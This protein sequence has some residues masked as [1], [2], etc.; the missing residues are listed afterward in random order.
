MQYEAG[1]RTAMSL[2][3][4]LSSRTIWAIICILF[5]AQA[6]GAVAVQHL[7]RM[8]L[9][10]VYFPVCLLLS[11]CAVS[12][13]FRVFAE[14]GRLGRW[15]WWIPVFLFGFVIF[16]LSNRSY[17]GAMPVFSPKVFHLVE[18][19]TLGLFLCFALLPVGIE[20][21]PTVFFSSVLLLGILFGAFDELH[22]AF[23][24]GRHASIFDVFFWDFP[25]TAIGLGIFLVIRRLDRD[26]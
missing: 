16:T 26:H 22:Q 13:L 10:Q 1:A 18:Y 2:D 14:S 3:N 25:G 5:G 17:P 24:P 15:Q 12:A 23:T 8:D 19:A 20:N 21:R 6:V 7:F 11:G 9:R 4:R